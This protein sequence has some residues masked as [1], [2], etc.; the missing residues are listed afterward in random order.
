ML[1]PTAGC[2]KNRTNPSPA[3]ILANPSAERGER[4]HGFGAGRCRCSSW[5]SSLR[6]DDGDDRPRSA[7][8]GLA[9]PRKDRTNPN[10][11][12]IPAIRRVHRGKRTQRNPCPVGIAHKWAGLRTFAP[13]GVPLVGPDPQVDGFFWLAGQGGYGVKTSPAL[14]RATASL[15][16]QGALPEDLTALGIHADDLAPA[17]FAKDAAL[18]AQA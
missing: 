2:Q 12:E 10:P 13:D 17:R 4:T 6:P 9:A 16:A 7:H 15:V 11:A 8:A 18:R 5:F 14:A 3:G 1:V